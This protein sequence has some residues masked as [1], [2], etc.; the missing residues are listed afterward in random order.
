MVKITYTIE[1]CGR[2]KSAKYT[3][4]LDDE[5]AKQIQRELRSNEAVASYTIKKLEVLWLAELQE[6]IK[7]DIL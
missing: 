6:A 5:E 7:A 4:E 2:S 1:V 3:A